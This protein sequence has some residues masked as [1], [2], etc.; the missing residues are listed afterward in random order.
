MYFQSLTVGDELLCVICS[1]RTERHAN[2]L[3]HMRKHSTKEDLKPNSQTTMCVLY[4]CTKCS[5]SGSTKDLVEKHIGEIHNNGDAEVGCTIVDITAQLRNPRDENA[6]VVKSNVN[7]GKSNVYGGKSNVDGGKSNVY[8]GTSREQASISASTDCAAN[9]T[10]AKHKNIIMTV[11]ENPTDSDVKADNTCTKSDSVA[12]PSKSLVS[13]LKSGSVTSAGTVSDTTSAVVQQMSPIPPHKKGPLIVSALPTNRTAGLSKIVACNQ[14]NTTTANVIAYQNE[15]AKTTLANSVRT[16][17][18]SDNHRAG[19]SNVTRNIGRNNNV[20]VSTVRH[21]KQPRN[22]VL[23]SANQLVSTNSLSNQKIVYM[24][25]NVSQFA[26]NSSLIVT[27][28]TPIMSLAASTHTSTV[29]RPSIHLPKYS[30]ANKVEDNSREPLASSTSTACPDS[31]TGQLFS[32]STS[33]A[34]PDSSTRQL[35]SVA[36]LAQLASNPVIAKL[37]PIVDKC[38]TGKM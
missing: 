37:L 23:V 31:S 3:V 24:T 14:D 5:Y 13:L 32:S 6:I 7:G 21:V 15:A 10:A 8:G 29:C 19:G 27:N 12:T 1:Y 9:E 34:C 36:S 17:Q 20:S 16:A 22:T 33:T 28:P 18:L 26:T 4:N 2:L 38:S 30:L 25:T 35:F 11:K